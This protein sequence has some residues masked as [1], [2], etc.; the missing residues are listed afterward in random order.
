MGCPLHVSLDDATPVIPSIA[1][2]KRGEVSPKTNMPP[3]VC[4]SYSLLDF[5]HARLQSR[6]S[7]PRDVQ[8]TPELRTDQPLAGPGCQGLRET[9]PP[10][11]DAAFVP[12]RT[13]TRGRTSP[14]APTAGAS[15]S[16]RTPSRI[17]ARRWPGR[18]SRHRRSCP[19]GMGFASFCREE[20]RPQ[21]IRTIVD[22]LV[23]AW[24]Q[25]QPQRCINERRPAVYRGRPAVYS[26]P[27]VSI[28]EALRNKEGPLIYTPRETLIYTPQ[29][30]TAHLYTTGDRSSI[31]RRRIFPA[32]FL[33]AWR[34]G[35]GAGSEAVSRPMG[36]IPEGLTKPPGEP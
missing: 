19:P 34:L 6:Q 23:R 18:W 32:Q 5:R 14:S 20:F 12:A 29:E 21:G 1:G 35:G 11:R 7:Q 33:E 30:A 9:S 25:K 24:R 26:D 13:P 36:H 8:G 15:G 17:S 27:P 2:A 3:K 31:H 16:A 28:S 22:L 4:R 10:S